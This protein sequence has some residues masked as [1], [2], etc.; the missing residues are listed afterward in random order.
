M[1]MV[2]TNCQMS[3]WYAR[4]T[5][6]QKP[7]ITLTLACATAVNARHLTSREEHSWSK[8]AAHKGRH[9]RR[10][11]FDQRLGS[12]K[13]Q[14]AFQVHDNRHVMPKNNTCHAVVRTTHSVKALIQD[15][16]KANGHAQLSVAILS[17]ATLRPHYVL[18]LPEGRV[19]S[20]RGAGTHDVHTLDFMLFSLS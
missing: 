10:Q 5:S 7:A 1:Y 14:H 16:A 19:P 2:Y 12:L 17:V 3:I 11:R 9:S 6:C 15:L 20:L 4:L 13:H 18:M 8:D